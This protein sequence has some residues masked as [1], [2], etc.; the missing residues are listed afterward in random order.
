[1][2]VNS[3]NLPWQHNSKLRLTRFGLDQQLPAMAVGDNVM[4]NVQS[5]PRSLPGSFGGEE[6]LENAG[7]DFHGNSWSIVA[8]LDDHALIFL[9]GSYFYF[10]LAVHRI[11]G[12]VDDVGPYLVELTGISFDARQV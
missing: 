2:F 7:L 6:R 12:I 4:A 11:D 3:L 5:Q 10:S 1:M 8:N 9:I